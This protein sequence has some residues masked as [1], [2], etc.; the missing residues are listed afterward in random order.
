[1]SRQKSSEQER[2]EIKNTELEVTGM[3]TLTA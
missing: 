2:R 3:K 1:M